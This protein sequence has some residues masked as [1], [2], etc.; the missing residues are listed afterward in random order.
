MNLT[1]LNL[2]FSGVLS[3]VFYVFIAILIL[4]AMVT[5]HEFGHFIAGRKLGFKINEFSVGF[6][7]VLFQRTTKDGIL[8]SLR[9][10]PLGGYC[11]FD[12]EDSDVD[13]PT[14]FNNQ[15]PWKRL[16]VLFNGAFFNFLSAVLF[17]FILS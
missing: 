1:L 7:K 5:I 12:G 17:S 15:K 8:V 4:L 6:G 16:I 10:I 3:F 2:T 11:A 14:A 13:S 9:L